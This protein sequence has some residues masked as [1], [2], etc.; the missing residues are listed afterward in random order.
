MCTGRCRSFARLRNVHL[1][2]VCIKVP[3]VCRLSVDGAD[4]LDV[5]QSLVCPPPCTQPE[6]V[7]LVAKTHQVSF[8]PDTSRSVGFIFKLFHAVTQLSPGVTGG[9][10]KVQLPLCHCSAARAIF[11]LRQKQ[12]HSAAPSSGRPDQTRP[13]LVPGA[14]RC[15]G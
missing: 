10:I 11:C 13:S 6:R 7:S 1:L 2:T 3:F 14:T 12:F 9:H 8:S 5:R 4:R 15:D